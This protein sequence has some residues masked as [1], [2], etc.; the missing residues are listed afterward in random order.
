MPVAIQ[1]HHLK[2]AC[3]HPFIFFI[4]VFIIHSNSQWQAA[5]PAAAAP[6]TGPSDALSEMN[7]PLVKVC[8]LS[9]PQGHKH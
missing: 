3:I 9:S 6:A 5:A 7:Y 1:P 4:V 8:G 2:H